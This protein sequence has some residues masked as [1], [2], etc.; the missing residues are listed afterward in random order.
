MKLLLTNDDGIESPGLDALFDAL[1][2][3]HEVWILAPDGERSGMSNYVTLHDPLRLRRIDE[4]RA[5]SSGSPAD[6]VILGLQD[7]LP[8]KPDAVLS[9]INMGP[10][11]GSDILFSGTAAAARQAALMGIP[12]IALSLAGV[13]APFHFGPMQA[14][15]RENLAKLAELWTQDHFL[16]INAPNKPDM[17]MPVEITTTCVRVYHGGLAQFSSPRGDTYFF[18]NGEPADSDPVPGTDEYAVARGSISMSAIAL[19]PV[20][21]ERADRYKE[22]FA[23]DGCRQK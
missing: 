12:G 3:E 22:R 16:N 19:Y 2:V 1:S 14:F 17:N 9:G 4:R 21:H 8:V 5:V 6:C 11:L 18:V 15:I 13:C 23:E 7:A 20:T 10:N